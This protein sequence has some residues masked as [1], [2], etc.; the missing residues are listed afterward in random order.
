M[1]QHSKKKLTTGY[2]LLLWSFEEENL[3]LGIIFSSFWGRSRNRRAA[4]LSVGI[5]WTSWRSWNRPRKKSTLSLKFRTG[6]KRHK[7]ESSSPEISHLLNP[8]VADCGKFATKPL[9]TYF[10]IFSHNIQLKSKFSKLLICHGLDSDDKNFAKF[11][12]RFSWKTAI[13]HSAKSENNY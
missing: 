11:N 10:Y 1:N 5:R 6:Y 3:R 4:T 7:I 9:D 8:A 13:W 2:G 12:F